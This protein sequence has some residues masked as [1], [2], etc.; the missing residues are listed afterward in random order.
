MV[1]VIRNNQLQMLKRPKLKLRDDFD[2][3]EFREKH[4]SWCKRV[5]RPTNDESVVFGLIHKQSNYDEVSWFFWK[6]N[7]RWCL[8]QI[9]KLLEKIKRLDWELRDACEFVLGYYTTQYQTK[10]TRSWYVSIPKTDS[11]DN[12]HRINL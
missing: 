5:G 1:A 6:H 4:L 11:G 7:Q 10:H 8:H 3:E 9:D 12:S 2:Y